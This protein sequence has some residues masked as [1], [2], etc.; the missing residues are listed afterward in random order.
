MKRVDIYDLWY[1]LAVYDP[2]AQP[3]GTAR[4]VRVRIRKGQRDMRVKEETC[5]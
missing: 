2:G 5:G 1:N 4:I 3:G